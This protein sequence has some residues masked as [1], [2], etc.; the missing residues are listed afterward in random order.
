MTDQMI[1]PE[2]LSPEA[3]GLLYAAIDRQVESAKAKYGIS[4]YAKL[5]L[6]GY[7]ADEFESNSKP[8]KPYSQIELVYTCI[9]KLIAG[10]AGLPPVVSTID[11]RI[12]ESGPA[13]DCLFNNPA[14]TWERFVADSIGFFSLFGEVF[15]LFP[16][17]TGTRPNE[18]M[19]VGPKQMK[20]IT[21]NRLADGDLI[22]W[23]YRTSGGARIPLS[24]SEVY[25]WRAFN[26]DDLHR[27]IG[28]L[29]AAANSMNYSFASALYNASALGN[30]AEPGIILSAPG[31]LDDDQ[32]RLLR[33]QFDARHKGAG[34]AK[35]TALL[36]GG[37]EAKTVAMKM[38]DMEVAKITEM[39]DKKI[40]STFGVPPGVAGLVTEAQYS[41]GPAMRDFIFNTIIPLAGVFAGNVT[42]G[43]VSRFFGSESRSVGVKDSVSL[44]AYRSLPLSRR[45][46]FRSACCKA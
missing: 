37:L 8:S 23:E 15:W 2:R 44:S 38:T 10:V 40:C 31:K 42:Q 26:P 17:L 13:Y 19:V 43:I 20:P 39:S 3:A 25:Q 33:S 30:G 32:V 6:A 5:W 1:Q 18:I 27:G 9:N 4:Q 11:E 45:R 21:A 28:P 34:K 41:H 35:R 22:G 24:L 16:D 46:E 29:Q 14:I 7:D 36:T 12:V